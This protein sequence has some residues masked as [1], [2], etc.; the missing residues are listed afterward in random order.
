MRRISPNKKLF[1]PFTYQQQTLPIHRPVALYIR[2]S[3]ENQV[4]ENKSSYV[5]QDEE[6]GERLDI[7]GFTSILKIDTDQGKSGQVMKERD[8]EMAMLERE[9]LDYLE[10]LIKT[11][12]IGAVAAYDASRFY[13]DATHVFYAQ[14]IQLLI[15]YDIPVIL[16]DEENGIRVFWPNRQQDMDALREEFKQAAFYL[17]HI[18]GKVLP[19]KAKAIERN[20]SYGGGSVPMGYIIGE[21]E[22]RKYYV[23]YEP[24]AKLIRFIFKRYRELGG[25]LPRLGRELRDTGFVFPAFS[26]PSKKPHVALDF[27]TQRKGY[28]LKTRNALVSILTNV[29]YIGWYVYDDA[30][31]SKEA[32]DPIVDY[33]DFLYAYSRLSTYTLDGEINTNKPQVDRHFGTGVNALLEGLLH[34]NGVPAY[35][36][37]HMYRARKDIN[38]FNSTEIN[39]HVK[40][41]DTV[42]SGAFL[43]VL[44]ALKH[45]TKE[46]VGEPTAMDALQATVDAMQEEK[47]QEVISLDGALE[48]IEKGIREW[49]LAKRVAMH[50]EYEP[51]VTEATREL[52]SLHATKALVK[53]KAVHVGQEQQQLAKTKSLIEQ[54]VDD[55]ESMLFADK[56]LLVQLMVQ[57]ANMEM[58]APHMIK[59]T[60]TLKSPLVGCMVGY[61][62]RKCGHKL[63]YTPEELATLAALYPAADRAVILQALPVR[64][65][66]SIV[67][68]AGEMGISRTTR[69]NTSG[70][71]ETLSY[72]DQLVIDELAH[73]HHV[74]LHKGEALWDMLGAL[75]EMYRDALTA[76][77]HDNNLLASPYT[78]AAAYRILERMEAEIDDTQSCQNNVLQLGQS[79]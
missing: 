58:I 52:K 50:E 37:Y 22:D 19:A 17:R 55:W 26:V 41:L 42:F 15:K 30:I 29:A 44:V 13:R 20:V 21:T 40:D 43:A 66:I 65:W 60:V 36:M 14:F 56:K 76:G 35:V 64:T 62:F 70:I 39:V 61:F 16:Y 18:Y 5:L 67:Q 73:M 3:T 69:L 33:G 71:D 78:V 47:A 68:Q 25:N 8:G 59:V 7:V 72:A 77:Q 53:E 24:H 9:G 38:S 11:G 1:K 57:S 12:K 32:H 54:A 45:Y 4:K 79:K 2:Q 75:G 28:V 74:I 46:K 63:L 31:I 48:N 51:G 27:D 6:M 49:E 10:H 34:N 23:I